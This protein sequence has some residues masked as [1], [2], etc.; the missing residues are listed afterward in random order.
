MSPTD[1]PGRG[2][3]LVLP[4]LVLVVGIAACCVAV[5]VGPLGR[6]VLAGVRVCAGFRSLDL[7]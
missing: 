2:A 4:V 5:C 1:S 3:M 7:T 6:S